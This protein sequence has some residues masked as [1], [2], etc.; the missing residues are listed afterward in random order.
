MSAPPWAHKAKV[1]VRCKRD[2]SGVARI[3]NPQGQYM[4]RE[5]YDAEALGLHKRP[6]GR[7][8]QAEDQG[9]APGSTEAADNSIPLEEVVNAGEGLGAHAH[10]GVDAPRDPK[11][12]AHCGMIL[13]DSAIICTSC[14]MNSTT[15]L[16]LNGKPASAAHDCV[17]CGYDMR[18]LRTARCPECG[19]VNTRAM[20]L[21]HVPREQELR[22]NY[23][24]PAVYAALGLLVSVP[25]V[26]LRSGWPLVGPHLLW[27]ALGV[28]AGVI[29]YAI[30]AVLWVGFE[31]PL[32][33]GAARIVGVVCLCDAAS[34]FGG[35]IPFSGLWLIFPCVAYVAL[36]T[37]LF[38]MDTQDAVIITLVT[39]LVFVGLWFVLRFVL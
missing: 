23:L 24:R 28:L 2:C 1:C 31:A 38:D 21:E 34:Q 36:L 9:P 27:V 7:A 14:G 17:K 6:P 37:D 16:F 33:V 39:S 12:C 10:A 30:C 3:K 25:V 11:M 5:C 29:G 26:G 18:G 19:T 22:D 4:C 20:R 15:G 8:S 32:H 35:I 13:K